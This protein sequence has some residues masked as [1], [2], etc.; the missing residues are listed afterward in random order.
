MPTK[1][2]DR[3]TRLTK[4]PGKSISERYVDAGFRYTGPI[5]NNPEEFARGFQVFTALEHRNYT[6]S[7]HA[8]K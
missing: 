8:E 6:Y 2:K 4:R 7:T 1:K 3:K 5:Y